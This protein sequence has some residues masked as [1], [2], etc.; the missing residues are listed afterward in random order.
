MINGC[1]VIRFLTEH[2]PGYGTPEEWK[3]RVVYGNRL[4]ETISGIRSPYSLG[5]E[6]L[7]L[8]AKWHKLWDDRKLKRL[9]G[10]SPL[11]SPVCDVCG[12]DTL[13]GAISCVGK[14]FCNACDEAGE[15]DKAKKKYE[16]M[17]AQ[18]R[19]DAEQRRKREEEKR[20]SDNEDLLSGAFHWRDG[21]YFKRMN[22][23]AVLLLK[24]NGQWLEME[25]IPPNEWASIIASVSDVG[26]TADKFKS[27]M[28]FHGDLSNSN[29]RKKI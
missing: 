13:D 3:I 28:E 2:Y 21:R 5:R 12:R 7:K 22:N 4:L 26:E 17:S 25:E 16:E 24:K 29:N 9:A 19:V 20:Q 15:I 6:E 23:G 10:K 1:E 14:V 27:A 18:I 11:A 8:E